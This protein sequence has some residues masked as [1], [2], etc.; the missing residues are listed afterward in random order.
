M[1]KY[2]RGQR[3]SRELAVGPQEVKEGNTNGE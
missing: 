1:T 3:K 2:K